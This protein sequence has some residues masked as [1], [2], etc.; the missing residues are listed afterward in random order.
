[1]NTL[2]NPLT[3]LLGNWKGE[4]QGNF[5]TLSPFTF[6]DQMTFKTLP[7][8][9]SLEPLVHFEEIAWIYVD[10]TEKFKH[11]ETG[12]FRPIND[13]KIEL[14]VTHNTGRIEVLQGEFELIDIKKRSF[15]LVFQT[16]FLRN[17]EGLVV[18]TSSQKVLDYNGENLSYIH[19]MATVEV[20]EKT[21]HLK[22]ELQ[23]IGS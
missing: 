2:I 21:N 12:F 13:S 14:Q 23:R 17:A 9:F 15:K 19:A 3:W 7:E 8:S 20:P 16:S 1:M 4:G 6:R 22:V 5:P 18:A 10:G 11:W